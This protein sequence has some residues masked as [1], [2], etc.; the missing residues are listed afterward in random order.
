MTAAGIATL[1]ITQAILRGEE[2]ERTAGESGRTDQAP[3]QKLATVETGILQVDHRAIPADLAE[4]ISQSLW[5]ASLLRLT[6]A[7]S[8]ARVCDPQR[9]AASGN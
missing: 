7:R 5:S 1:M 4:A 3:L 2:R 9:I 8:G 6:E